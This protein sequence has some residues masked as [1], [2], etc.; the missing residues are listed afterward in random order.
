MISESSY[1]NSA[2]TFRDVDLLKLKQI[3]PVWAHRFRLSWVKKNIFFPISDSL[4]KQIQ[5]RKKYALVFDV[6]PQYKPHVKH[7]YEI[8]NSFSQ[9]KNNFGTLAELIETDLKNRTKEN[10]KT[11][12]II[13]EW[14]VFV[15]WAGMCFEKNY[16]DSI[17]F[18][19]EPDYSRNKIV[20]MDETALDSFLVKGSEVVLYEKDPLQA[21]LKE[22]RKEI[23][24]QCASKACLS[25]SKPKTKFLYEGQFK[26]MSR[27][28]RIAREKWSKLQEASILEGK[29]QQDQLENITQENNELFVE[30][31]ADRIKQIAQSRD[32]SLSAHSPPSEDGMETSCID[33]SRKPKVEQSE[34]AKRWKESGM[35]RREIAEKLFKNDFENGVKIE[36]LKRRVDRLTQ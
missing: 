16:D 21:Q 10:D 3:V 25:K 30:A 14:R 15:V 2:A 28:D 1:H 22:N 7:I 32:Q 31:C 27:E 4:D 9:Y 13:K 18:E 6:D 8:C 5:Y 33:Y 17:T 19:I 11:L 29:K 12:E 20:D 23:Q 36:T 35:T 24:H 34:I 26:E